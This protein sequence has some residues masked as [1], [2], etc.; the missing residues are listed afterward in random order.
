MS[1]ALLLHHDFSDQHE[2]RRTYLVRC[3]VPTCKHPAILVEFG[4]EVI[5]HL[6]HSDLQSPLAVMV[7]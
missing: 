2:C 5:D 7:A 1:V 3:R 6:G 4:V